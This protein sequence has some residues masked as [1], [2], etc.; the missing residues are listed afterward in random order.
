MAD[1][2]TPTLDMSKSQPLPSAASSTPTLDLSKSVPIGAPPQPAAQPTVQAQPDAVS[3]A[4]TGAGQGL[5][6][7]VAP[8]VSA[9]QAAVEPPQ[10]PTEQVLHALSPGGLPLYRAAKGLVLL[11]NKVIQSTPAEY[12]Q[13]ITDYNKAIQ[14]F[15]NHDWRNAIPSAIEAA[16]GPAGPLAELSGASKDIRE[17]AEGTRPGGNLATPLT[18]VAVTAGGMLLGDELGDMASSGM[19][20]NPFRSNMTPE[21]EEAI[22]TGVSA[23][24]PA[25]SAGNAVRA[26]IQ[27]NPIAEG[28]S[29]VLDEPINAIEK[30]KKAAYA[31]ID[32]TAGFDLKELKTS[33]SNDE[34][35]LKQLGNTPADLAEKKNLQA[36]IA[37]A[38]GRIVNAE[39]K[40]KTAGINPDS[41]DALHMRQM[42]GEDLRKAIS[43]T[44]DADGSINV[45]ALLRRTKNMR[46]GARGDRLAQFMGKP[47]ADQFIE[48]LTQAQKMGV[49]SLRYQR[50]AKWLGALAGSAAAGYGGYEVAKQA[51]HLMSEP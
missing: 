23:A 42:A 18:R 49:N 43:Q 3:R 50:I 33:L 37:D 8:A 25:G 14:E 32:Q 35:K 11:A 47:A 24:T 45:N 22:R 34:Y 15:K 31:K 16:T 20:R 6:G 48:D 29:T 5:E 46:Y 19:L 1:N 27:T 36:S 26:G 4:I 41:G 12:Q 13:N 9:V 40:L 2:Q 44:T 30:A 39:S 7:L 10:T 51:G 21:A 38:R 28:G 17:L